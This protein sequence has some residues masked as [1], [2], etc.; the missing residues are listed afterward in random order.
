MKTFKATIKREQ[1]T[2]ECIVT[3]KDEKEAA[4]KIFKIC[5]EKVKVKAN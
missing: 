5:G 1:H 3:A 4:E 2:C